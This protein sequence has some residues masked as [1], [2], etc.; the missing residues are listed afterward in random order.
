[1]PAAGAPS[2]ACMI[3]TRQPPRALVARHVSP[4]RAGAIELIRSRFAASADK[5]LTGDNAAH[6]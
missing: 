3:P 4:S 1:M 5:N 2:T 6:A